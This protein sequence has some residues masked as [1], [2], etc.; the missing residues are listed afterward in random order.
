MHNWAKSIIECVK[1]KVDSMGMDNLD[2]ED[3]EELKAW[4]CIAKDVAEYDYYYHITEAMEK[5]ENKYGENY[6]ENGKFYT[7]MR[8]SMGRYTSR[9]YKYDPSVRGGMETYRD[10]DKGS[11]RMYYTDSNYMGSSSR[12][13]RAKRGYEES[14]MMNPENDNMEKINEVFEV[15]D[16][17]MKAL[18]PKMTPTEKAFAKNKLMSMST[19]MM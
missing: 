18:K 1:S 8:N 3:V 16:E 17:D 4:V 7:P 5:P 13:D 14:K 9:G 15:L 19:A 11:G 2:R 6:D 12:Y 10:M